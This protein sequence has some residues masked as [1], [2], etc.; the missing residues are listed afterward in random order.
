MRPQDVAERVAGELR[1]LGLSVKCELDRLAA[2]V[3]AAY[4]PRQK[5]NDFAKLE[6]ARAD[7]K[8]VSEQIK[9]SNRGKRKAK[10][11]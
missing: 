1:R 9:E 5:V 8:A 7:F 4:V 3:E 6:R 11:P 10:S 2:E